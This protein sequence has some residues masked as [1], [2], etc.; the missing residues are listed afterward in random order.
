MQNA[1]NIKQFRSIRI[2]CYVNWSNMIGIFINFSVYGTQFNNEK[3]LFIE[4]C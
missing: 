1:F 4:N 2:Q 3:N